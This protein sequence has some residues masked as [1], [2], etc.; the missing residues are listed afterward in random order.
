MAPKTRPKNIIACDMFLAC[1]ETTSLVGARRA[2]KLVHMV[3]AVDRAGANPADQIFHMFEP[4]VAID[5]FESV[6]TLVGR[7]IVQQYKG[8]RLII[9]LVSE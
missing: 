9:R 6:S 4:V 3:D 7:A 1:H 5:N 8:A 2:L